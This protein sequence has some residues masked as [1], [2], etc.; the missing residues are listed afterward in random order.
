MIMQNRSVIRRFSMLTASFLAAF[1]FLCVIGINPNTH[2]AA[3][4]GDASSGSLDNSLLG[5]SSRDAVFA[6]GLRARKLY[7]SLERF[8]TTRHSELEPGSLAR[9]ELR[10]EWLIALMEKAVALPKS[11]REQVWSELQ[12]RADEFDA[13]P[14]DAD[15]AYAVLV[16]YQ[17]AIA[18]ANHGALERQE[19]E[20]ISPPDET[21]IPVAVWDVLRLAYEKLS[22]IEKDLSDRVR[23]RGIPGGGA[24]E[25]DLTLDQLVSLRRFVQWRMGRVLMEQGH[26]F[27][28]G[29][30]D[31]LL[32][33][34]QA[35][36]LL[37]RLA[38]LDINNDPLIWQA[39]V[40]TLTCYR[41]REMREDMQRILDG[42][43]VKQ[44]P[45]EFALKFLSEQILLDLDRGDSIAAI[46]NAFEDR[47]VDGRSVPEYE[48]ACLQAVLNVCAKLTNDPSFRLPADIISPNGTAE[49]PLQVDLDA[50][51]RPEI[52]HNEA[53]LRMTSL[54]EQ[55]GPYWAR[56]ADMLIAQN[57]LASGSNVALLT[58][59][60]EREYGAQQFDEAIATYDRARAAA[61]LIGDQAIAFKLGG[62]AASIE[63]E[64]GRNQEAMTR[65]REVAL[66][67]PDE[68][69]ADVA[70]YWAI[71][72][73]R[74]IA[75]ELRS[76]TA[77]KQ[78]EDMMANHLI[79]WPDRPGT[80]EVRWQLGRLK[81]AKGDPSAASSV[82]FEIDPAFPMFEQVIA[83]LE[84]CCRDMI[85]EAERDSQAEIV[86][87][88][89]LN[90]ARGFESFLPPIGQTDAW[91]RSQFRA[92]ASAAEFY[93]LT[94]LDG[95]LNA[96]RV[97]Q[98][99][100]SEAG[101]PPEDLIPRIR[102]LLVVAQAGTGDPAIAS[103]TL[104]AFLSGPVTEL[105]GVLFEIDRLARTAPSQQRT[106]LLSLQDRILQKLKIRINELD[107]TQ[108]NS[109]AWLQ[110]RWFTSSGLIQE[111]VA[112]YHSLLKTNPS[113]LNIVRLEFAQ[114]L[115]SQ[116]TADLLTEALTQWR[117]IESRTSE[118]SPAWF[119]AKYE[120]ARAHL[121]L[122]NS[123]QAARM[124]GL[125]RVLYPEM[126]GPELKQQFDEL[127]RRCRN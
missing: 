107:S 29:S 117:E 120:I 63:R 93:F 41:L 56:R 17:N 8:C 77:I 113:N 7:G 1:G 125:L 45:P 24:P 101:S 65:F 105:L 39:R 89:A 112:A 23:E 94:T 48:L 21:E 18:L 81:E 110:A 102:G 16:R 59:S 97:L 73:A 14:I 95:Y 15:G 2:L 13:D 10:A 106:P 84:R 53:H 40:D 54:K 86:S 38:T 58:I 114:L 119:D 28:D 74:L 60:A 126:G 26:C 31:R 49:N 42:L 103:A 67:F 72:H 25:N 71:E 61:E 44:K 51:N 92:A 118:A 108:R 96:N 98:R 85:A 83:S 4:V 88:I 47:T 82:Y 116:N 22:A 127:E 37:E 46:R 76:E 12:Q 6:Q 27:P 35:R 122:G 68:E 43:S 5:S 57:T 109:A 3:D 75:G 66:A 124:V 80:D 20:W 90:A 52:W 64:R 36:E 30:D 34:G 69:Q 62:V 32:L 55:S 87:S 19:W 33:I 11:Q 91:T 70:H 115:S 9:A 50:L 78:Y 100:L 104:D 79:H 111:A 99:V 121:R 123:E